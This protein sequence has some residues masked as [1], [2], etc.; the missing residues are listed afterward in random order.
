ME[1]KLTLGQKFA[2]KLS[3][4]LGSWAFIGTQGVIFALWMTVNTI[5][6]KG[7]DKYPFVFLNL[8][9]GFESAFTAPILLMAGN[10]QSEMDR[11][12]LLEDLELD[13]KN[14]LMLKE[15]RDHFDSH[16]HELM[17]EYKK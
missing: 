2:D 3:E 11:K 15:M 1:D 16:F 14:D 4:V 5:H 8:I 6:P 7:I 17:K 9:V 10:R 12:R 13:K